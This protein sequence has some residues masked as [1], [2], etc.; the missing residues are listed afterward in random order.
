MTIAETSVGTPLQCSIAA[1]EGDRVRA[2]L[3]MLYS[4]TRYLDIALLDA[5]GG[6]ALY[7]ASGTASPLAEGAPELYPSPSFSKSASAWLFTIAAGHIAAGH[8]TVVLAQQ[9]T[10]TGTV[11]AH[12]TYP[13]R[14]RLY[15]LGPEPT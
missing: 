10:G 12:T 4:G 8:A 7:A 3:L 14:M 9:G 1:A 15:N 5:G 11:Y 2:E 6:I 13:W